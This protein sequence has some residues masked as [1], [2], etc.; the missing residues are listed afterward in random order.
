LLMERLF[1]RRSSKFVFFRREE[2]EK[3]NRD[4]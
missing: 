3:N 1:C 4:L 2:R